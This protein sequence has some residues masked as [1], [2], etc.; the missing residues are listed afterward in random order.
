M[1]NDPLYRIRQF[2]HA[3]RAVPLTMQE[4]ERV[5]TVLNPDAFVLYQT[6]PLGDQRHSLKI[7]DALD[8]Q[9]YRATPLLQAAL[10]HDV[11]KRN[12][13]LVYRTG[14]ILLKRFAPDALPRVA[15]ANEKSWRYP[16]YVS[17][18]H[19]VLGAQLAA[20]AG[21]DELALALMRAHQESAPAF[22]GAAAAQLTEW[23]RALKL[24]DDVN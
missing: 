9:G 7:F 8:A 18:H 4:Q 20:R 22:H 15:S 23:H 2:F 6:M 13:G 16:F 19:P 21:V 3:L 10:L 12:V 5:Q 17:L 14:V 1:T 11:A 24:L